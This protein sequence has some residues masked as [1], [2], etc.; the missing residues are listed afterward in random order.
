[1]LFYNELDVSDF[2]LLRLGDILKFAH[3]PF[4]LY[5]FNILFVNTSNSRSQVPC[6]TFYGFLVSTIREVSRA[7]GIKVYFN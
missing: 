5:Q 2:P 4:D 3:I 7:N 1:M 6:C